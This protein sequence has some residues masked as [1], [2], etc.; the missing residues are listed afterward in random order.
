[1]TV[2]VIGGDHLGAIPDNLKESGYDR[3]KHLTGRKVKHVKRSFPENCDLVLVLTD[4]VGTNLSRV[5]KT[6]AKKHEVPV[7]FARRSWAC[8]AKEMNRINCNN[9]CSKPKCPYS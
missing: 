4:Y 2:A 9:C 1:M 3:V 5:I 8:I 6:E 7:I